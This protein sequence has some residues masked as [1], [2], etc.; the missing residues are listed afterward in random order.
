MRPEPP[1][2]HRQPQSAATA[3]GARGAHGALALDEAA[4]TACNL[5]AVEC[6]SWCLSMTWQLQEEPEAASGPQGGGRR[7]R[8]KVLE[9]FTLDAGLCIYCGICVAVCP[10]DALAWVPAA[11][12]PTVVAGAAATEL[13]TEDRRTL[14]TRWRGAASPGVPD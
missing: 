8:T 14:A 10:F 2:Q 1:G 11:V 9:G 13:L 5:C 4:C 12:P 7:R 3:H 6:P